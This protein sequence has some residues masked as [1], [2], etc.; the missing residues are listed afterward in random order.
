[1]C[2]VFVCPQMTWS[3]CPYAHGA[4]FAPSLQ[5]PTLSDTQFSH[6]G[7]GRYPKSLW[8]AASVMFFRCQDLSRGK[9]LS[10]FA[11][12]AHHVRS[13]MWCQL[14]CC[15][16]TFFFCTYT[17]CIRNISKPKPTN[18]WPKNVVINNNSLKE[19]LSALYCMWHTH[20]HI[21]VLV[22]TCTHTVLV[23]YT[24]LFHF[25]C[26][27]VPRRLWSHGIEHKLNIQ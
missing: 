11:A 14:Y 24:F 12:S 23:S 20:T 25:I 8:S 19:N 21:L 4:L 9:L 27:C 26:V 6:H 13:N 16:V 17:H 2:P 5:P 10:H 1:M 3:S 18:P 22:H 7:E 15:S